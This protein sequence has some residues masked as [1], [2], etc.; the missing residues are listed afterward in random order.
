MQMQ[1]QLAF[2]KCR[3]FMRGESCSISHYFDVLTLSH[4]PGPNEITALDEHMW[5][6]RFVVV[7]ALPVK[8]LLSY[9]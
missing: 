5:W 3:S 9:V 7:A 1:L 4:S 8:C 6:I 2:E